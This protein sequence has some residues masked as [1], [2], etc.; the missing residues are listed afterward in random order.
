MTDSSSA[1]R[2]RWICRATPLGCRS[3]QRFLAP[4]PICREIAGPQ[5]RGE[6]SPTRWCRL[7]PCPT[8]RI[9]FVGHLSNSDVPADA[10]AA[11]RMFN[12]Q[13]TRYEEPQRLQKPVPPDPFTTIVSVSDTTRPVASVAVTSN[14]SCSQPKNLSLYEAV[15]LTVAPSSNHL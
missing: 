2:A 8:Q 11:K 3:N 1:D 14:W 13:Q 15:V 9:G 7:A 10:C 5:R 4:Q 12:D 6:S